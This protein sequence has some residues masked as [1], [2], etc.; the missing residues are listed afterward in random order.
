VTNARLPAADQQFFA[1]R[2]CHVDFVAGE[3][4]GHDA[5]PERGVLDHVVFLKRP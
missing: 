3:E 4:M 2:E 1:L 5:P